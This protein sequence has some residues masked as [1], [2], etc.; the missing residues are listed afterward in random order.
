MAQNQ[1]SKPFSERDG[2]QALQGSFNT[3]D[4][5]LTTNGFLVGLVGH[6]IS[7]IDTAAPNLGSAVAGDDFAFS[8]N[9]NLL[10]TI[11][12]LYSDIS[13]SIFT[14]AERVT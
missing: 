2:S 1:T 9:G 13:K 10:Y 6:K 11:R 7:R 3:V 4:K 5:S 14:S 8:D 12:I